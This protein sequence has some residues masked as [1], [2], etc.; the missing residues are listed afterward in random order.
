[1]SDLSSRDALVAHLKL[2]IEKLRPSFYGA[3]S[4]RMARLLEQMELQLEDLEAPATEDDWQ[5]RMRRRGRNASAR[6]GASARRANRF[7]EHLPRERIVTPARVKR[8]TR[9]SVEIKRVFN[10]NFQVYGVR[11]VWRQ[12]LREGHDVAR[13]TVA[14]LVK[15]MALQGVIR[16][17]RVCT[18]PSPAWRGGR[19][20]HGMSTGRSQALCRSARPHNRRGTHRRS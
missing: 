17:R 7:P 18:M 8:D 3:R 5:H 1:L 2:E 9:L 6:S 12:L 19:R 16:G 13:C 10:E 20:G 14:R 15:K 11:K 4:E